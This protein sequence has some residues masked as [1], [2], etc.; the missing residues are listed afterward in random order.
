MTN[1]IITFRMGDPHLRR[2]RTAGLA[3]LLFIALL[4]VGLSRVPDRP[5]LMAR[6]ADVARPADAVRAEMLFARPGA[7]AAV[8]DGTAGVGA[9]RAAGTS[10]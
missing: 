4:T 3:S 1:L 6:P 10:Q 9:R 8:V 2:L 7:A 5:A